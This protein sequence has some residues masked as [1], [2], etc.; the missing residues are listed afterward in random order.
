MCSHY[1]LFLRIAI[2]INILP[3]LSQFLDPSPL[4][5]PS[6]HSDRSWATREWWG[7]VR[8]RAAGDGWGLSLHKARRCLP[9]NQMCCAPARLPWPVQPS[10][11]GPALEQ[12]RVRDTAGQQPAS[13]SPSPWNLPPRNASTSLGMHRKKISCY[14]VCSLTLYI[15]RGNNG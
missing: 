12:L 2:K 3:P 15:F 6:S 8:G 9:S 1:F 7:L 5:T 13:T 4:L 14:L 11:A 10:V